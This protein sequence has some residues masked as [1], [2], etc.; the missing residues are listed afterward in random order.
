M[1][2]FQRMSLKALIIYTG[3]ESVVYQYSAII[4]LSGIPIQHISQCLP[5]RLQSL[6]ALLI[7]WHHGTSPDQHNLYLTLNGFTTHD[8]ARYRTW[9]NVVTKPLHL[10]QPLHQSLLLLGSCLHRNKG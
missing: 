6:F 4:V 5:K 9:E 7:I 10:L 3:S 1:P 2:C 8:I